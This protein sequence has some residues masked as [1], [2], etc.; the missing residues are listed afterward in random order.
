MLP[1]ARKKNLVIQPL[2]DEILIYDLRTDRAHCLNRTASLVWRY[3]D[4]KTDIPIMSRKLASATG[5]PA[6]QVLVQL[7]LQRLHKAKLLDAAP[8]SET[9]QL[10]RRDVIRRLGKA[11]AITVP[12]VTSIIAP[13]A[14]QAAS[15]IANNA[16]CTSRAE[17]DGKCC[18]NKSKCVSKPG[19]G[20]KGPTCKF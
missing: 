3:C 9:I 16:A 12:L 5:E 11:A 2:D 18:C 13:E 4:G 6:N 8:D 15:C 7:A 10:S 17:W 19:G 14:A 1:K 20:C